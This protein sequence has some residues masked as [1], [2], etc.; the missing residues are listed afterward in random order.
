MSWLNPY[1]WLGAALIVAGLVFGGWLWGHSDVAERDATITTLDA[2]L[3]AARNSANLYHDAFDIANDG[4]LKARNTFLGL[5]AD[6]NLQQ[7]QGDR[8][9]AAGER[10]AAEAVKDN[11][12]LRARI[13]KLNNDIKRLSTGCVDATRPV[14]GVLQ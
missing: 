9:I 2:D 13:A 5:E 4:L 3:K 7:A 14:C 6:A 8:A 12:S 11:A 10:A 1:T